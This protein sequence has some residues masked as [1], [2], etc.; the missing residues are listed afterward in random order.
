[1]GSRCCFAEKS[2]T[3]TRTRCKT[4]GHMLLPHLRYMTIQELEELQGFPG[5]HLRIPAGVSLKAYAGMLGN[6]F[7]VPVVG[8]VALALLK[9]V[10]KIPIRFPDPWADDAGPVLESRLASNRSKRRRFNSRARSAGASSS[11]QSTL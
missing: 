1:M 6:A 10:G 4:G 3:L 7:S 9:T 2:P 5:G 11:H 8:R